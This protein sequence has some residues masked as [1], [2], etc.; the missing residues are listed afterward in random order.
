MSDADIPKVNLAETRNLV[1]PEE[2]EAA[3]AID[4]GQ[5]VIPDGSGGIT[6]HDTD[7]ERPGDLFVA[8]D[9][10]QRGIEWGD[11]YPTDSMVPIA[12][13]EG[14]Y[15]NLPLAT[16]ESVTEDDHVVPDASG[17]VRAAAGDGTEESAHLG[18]VTEAVDNSGGSA[19]TQVPVEVS[20]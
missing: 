12:R 15:L 1:E 10:R 16:G 20:F 13:I 18:L 2:R 8:L 7:A 14:G 17:D 11:E 3:A 19:T 4:A 5:L 9:A 6:P